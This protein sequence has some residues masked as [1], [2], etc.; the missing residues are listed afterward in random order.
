MLLLQEH[1][2][3]Y[4]QVGYTVGCGGLAVIRENVGFANV[5]FFDL[6]K[7]VEGTVDVT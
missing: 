1:D 3:V 6:Q 4:W 5:V 2:I 7:T